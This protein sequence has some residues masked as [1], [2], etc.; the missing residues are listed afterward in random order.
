MGFIGAAELVALLAALTAFVLVLAGPKGTWIRDVRLPLLSLLALAILRSLSNIPVGFRLGAVQHYAALAEP[1]VWY[2]LFYAFVQSAT[3]RQLRRSEEQQR[4]LLAS[5]P[6]RIFFKDSD[7]VFV[8][9][10]EPFARELGRPVR[11]LHRHHG[12]NRG[13]AGT[14]RIRAEVQVSGRPVA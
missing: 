11:H 1:P 14:A 5:L 9:A 12:T 2:F 4:I 3:H 6:Q 10:N 13:R 8:F 7:S